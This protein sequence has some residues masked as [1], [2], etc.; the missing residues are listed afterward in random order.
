M[1]K[2]TLMVKRTKKNKKAIT[3]RR[4]HKRK[5][6]IPSRK[7]RKNGG[8]SSSPKSERI[9][10]QI[11]LVKNTTTSRYDP[12]YKSVSQLLDWF[13]YSNSLRNIDIYT[14]IPGS[15]KLSPIYIKKYQAISEIWGYNSSPYTNYELLS[16]NNY[17][18]HSLRFFQ[19]FSDPLMRNL[20]R[21]S[22][23]QELLPG[24]TTEFLSTVYS[25]IDFIEESP[26]KDYIN[27]YCDTVLPHFL[28]QSNIASL[29]YEL[30]DQRWQPAGPSFD[31]EKVLLFLSLVA[32]LFL[33]LVLKK[34]EDM[35]LL[36]ETAGIKHL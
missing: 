33:L 36:L 9:L 2:R 21:L 8:G 29:F 10:S 28:S 24:D 6:R 27:W 18:G 26:N 25:T 34:W 32:R 31:D 7:L 15:K 23:G 16:H 1:V 30:A 13:K 14:G 5:L 17:K 35:R 12:N 19:Y 3:K 20:K 22:Q 11:V 4:H